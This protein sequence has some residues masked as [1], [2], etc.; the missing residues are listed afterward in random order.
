MTTL[1]E[2]LWDA[3]IALLSALNMNGGEGWSAFWWIYTD[4]LAWIPLAMVTAWWLLRRGGWREGLLL[5]LCVA[6]LFVLSDALLAH[7]MKPLVGRLRP[8]QDPLVQDMLTYYQDYRSGR[9]GFPSNHASNGFG[10][11]MLLWLLLRS[12]WTPLFALLWAV[13]SCYS[14]LYFGVHYPSD[15]LA[16]ALFGCLFGCL[17][18]FLYKNTYI[19]LIPRWHLPPFGSHYEGREAWPVIFVLLAT[20]CVLPLL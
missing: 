3:D 2:T 15:I 19:F 14:R 1:S 6:M 8:S 4:R 5:A 17:S 9:Y 13:G 7:V 16:G 10:V 18:Y 11:V 12:R 20:V